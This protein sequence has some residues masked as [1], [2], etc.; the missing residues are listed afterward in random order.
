MTW[1]RSFLLLAVLAASLTTAA[2][3]Q[4]QETPADTAAVLIDV[5]QQLQAEREWDTAEELLRYI[6]RHYAGTPAAADAERLLKQLRGIRTA[7]SGR[8]YHPVVRGVERVY[9]R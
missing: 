9:H 7:T 4:A 1:P 6:M 5:V 2:P 8:R 3:L